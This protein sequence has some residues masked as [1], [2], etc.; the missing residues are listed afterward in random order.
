MRSSNRSSPRPATATS[1]ARAELLDQL[2]RNPRRRGAGALRAVLGLPGG[3]RRTRSPAERDLL[4][5]LREDGIT[6][7]EVNQRVHGYEVDFFWPRLAFAIELDGYDGHKGRAA[8]ERDR[9][10]WATLRSTG[11]DVMPLTPR[12]VRDAPDTS[13][14]LIREALRRA[15][16]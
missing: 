4:R 11:V 7:F 8:F 16:A 2:E 5:L 13:L 3:P 10:K 9:L 15:G 1:R 6:G 12:R 14:S